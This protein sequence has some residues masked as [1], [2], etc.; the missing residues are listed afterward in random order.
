MRRIYRGN[1]A[2]EAC[3]FRS[4]YPAEVF[5]TELI[6]STG[7]TGLVAPGDATPNLHYKHIP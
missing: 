5:G 4:I 2:T 1:Y 7:P 3:I 6:A